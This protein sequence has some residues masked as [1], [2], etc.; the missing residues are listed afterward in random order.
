MFRQGDKNT[1]CLLDTFPLPLEPGGSLSGVCVER[2]LA[3]RVD[4]KQSV[5]PT[6]SENFP[7]LLLEPA[8]AQ[9]SSGLL[10]FLEVGEEHPQGKAGHKLHLAH[11]DERFSFVAAN[12]L[13]EFVLNSSDTNCIKTAG[14][15]YDLDIA[16]LL[17]VHAVNPF[18]KIPI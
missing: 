17:Y 15:Y 7:D 5:E 2:F 3:V 16:D 1:G 13:C 18:P 8:Q 9:I 6:L 10:H 14:K 12:G 4:G 11:I